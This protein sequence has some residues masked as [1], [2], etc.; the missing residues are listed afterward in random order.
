MPHYV[1]GCLQSRFYG[2]AGDPELAEQA[3]A[4]PPGVRQGIFAVSVLVEIQ[5]KLQAQS[6]VMSVVLLIFAIVAAFQSLGLP[7]EEEVKLFLQIV[8]SFPDLSKM[9]DFLNRKG[10]Q[11]RALDISDFVKAVTSAEEH[12]LYPEL[13]LVHTKKKRTDWLGFCRDF[14]IRVVTVWE[15]TKTL[16]DLYLKD[17]ELL[18]QHEKWIVS[19]ASQAEVAH[20]TSAIHGLPAEASA[21]CRTS[22]QLQP[23][24]DGQLIGGGSGLGGKNGTRKC[25]RCYTASAKTVPLTEH[26]CFLYAITIGKY[27]NAFEHTQKFASGYVQKHGCLPSASEAAEQLAKKLEES[28]KHYAPKKRRKSLMNGN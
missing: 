13:H 1:S 11:S 16:C 5:C 3:H 6:T 24:R 15:Q 27:P 17:E 23:P 18:K 26:Q 8:K 21:L 20:A 10:K 22:L 2:A 19:Q 28:N 12:A 7:P 14:N 4:A 25:N 9:P